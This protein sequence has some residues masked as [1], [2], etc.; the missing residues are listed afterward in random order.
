ML[1]NKLAQ[2][3]NSIKRNA[4]FVTKKHNLI[5]FI[6]FAL[7]A[8]FYVIANWNFSEADMRSDQAFI[9][10]MVVK[11]HNPGLYPKDMLMKSDRYYKF[12]IPFYRKMI[13]ALI[14]LTG[15]SSN[16][17]KVLFFVII[18]IY[19]CTSY[20][21]FQYMTR[22]WWLSLYLSL[23]SSIF[24]FNLISVL[25]PLMLYFSFVFLYIYLFLKWIDDKQRMYF[26]FF[27]AGLSI[28]IHPVLGAT[29][30]TFFLLARLF[31]SI[32][33]KKFK[34]GV[35]KEYLVFL[36][37]FSIGAFP[38][39]ISY[40]R[41]ADI[42]V[43]QMH[44]GIINS[45]IRFRFSEKYFDLSW[46]S[47]LL[48]YGMGLA[49]YKFLGYPIT[50]TSI[51]YPLFY[52]SV[53]ILLWSK[54]IERKDRLLLILFFVS[55]VISNIGQLLIIKGCD[56]LKLPYFFINIKLGVLLSVFVSLIFLLRFLN[57]LVNFLLKCTK[58]TISKYAAIISITVIV[59][60]L[61][62]NFISANRISF[63]NFSNVIGKGEKK[64]YYGKE[65]KYLEEVGM[66]ARK[67]TAHD[68]VFH[69]FDPYSIY[70][71]LFRLLS[72]RS[73]TISWSDASGYLYADKQ[74]LIEWY[75]KIRSTRFGEQGFNI[76][77]V[78][79][80]TG[81]PVSYATF[82]M[83]FS[84]NEGNN[85]AIIKY[86]KDIR[87]DYII[88]GISGHVS[89]DV[90]KEFSLALR[91]LGSIYYDELKFRDKVAII[92]VKGIKGRIEENYGFLKEES[93]RVETEYKGNV[94]KTTRPTR[95]KRYKL[96]IRVNDT[97][98]QSYYAMHVAK[99]LGADYVVLQDRLKDLPPLFNNKGYFV[100]STNVD[101]LISEVNLKLP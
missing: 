61:S 73:I 34:F 82:G 50:G 81:W 52:L 30:A 32:L 21:I 94:I 51:L 90:T 58:N 31:N 91:E 84:E 100:Y 69:Y 17:S 79:P 13:S 25:R 18:F 86:L 8:L 72:F 20:L 19:L 55:I 48:P 85:K 67:N 38:F 39:L 87:N 28:N 89:K 95:S 66:W 80:K 37:C 83:G 4:I 9:N 12:Y 40:L 78:D 11:D 29:F 76:V 6:T 62:Y 24:Y 98:I 92:A 49:T 65:A 53:I 41:A 23:V 44:A 57:E 60:L 27:L 101:Q 33:E 2:L 70:G 54:K 43:N 16:A 71:F 74:K 63:R 7:L 15:T 10:M 26:F 42:S 47:M 59:V 36:L 22:R 88:I 99:K 1:T 45:I 93:M 75:E 77:V 5:V 96:G 97:D 64:Y 68:S 35:V 46:R 14:S 3:L 56:Y